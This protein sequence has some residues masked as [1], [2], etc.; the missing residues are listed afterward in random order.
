[1]G[2]IFPREDLVTAI[3]GAELTIF[4]DFYDRVKGVIGELG[5]S[6][7]VLYTCDFRYVHRSMRKVTSRKC[8]TV[9]NIELYIQE[10][11]QDGKLHVYLTRPDYRRRYY[12]GAIDLSV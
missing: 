12:L 1:M 6:T 5:Y 3:P 10:Q 7:K 8:I 11:E 4:D 2:C 9:F